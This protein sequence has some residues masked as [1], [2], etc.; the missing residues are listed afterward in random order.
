MSQQIDIG[1]YV[2]L[3]LDQNENISTLNNLHNR[4]YLNEMQQSNGSQ[5]MDHLI[6]QLENIPQ[7]QPI[8]MQQHQQQQY[9]QQ[10]QMIQQQPQMIQQPPQYQ[11]QQQTQYQQQPPQYQQQPPQQQMIP[12]QQF[13][14]MQKLESEKIKAIK[15]LN[16]SESSNDSEKSELKKS[17]KYEK[18]NDGYANHN[19]ISSRVK[20][21][22]KTFFSHIN[23]T[24]IVIVLYIIFGNPYIN[25][26]ITKYIPYLQ[27]SPS[28][29]FVLK[30]IIFALLYHSIRFFIN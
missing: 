26:Y 2:N 20:S 30:L 29:L 5:M 21:E 18:Q 15:D 16:I 6:E 3:N 23:E 8:I 28:I 9:Q 22:Q 12:Q 25:L 10:P 7:T 14:I 13:S 19:L 24:V 4:Q 1:D 17:P 27:E 11:Q